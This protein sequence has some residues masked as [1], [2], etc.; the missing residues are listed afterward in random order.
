MLANPDRVAKPLRTCCTMEW[1]RGLGRSPKPG[2]SGPQHSSPRAVPSGGPTPR[3]PRA[4]PPPSGPRAPRGYLAIVPA[5]WQVAGRGAADAQRGRSVVALA[6]RADGRARGLAHVAGRVLAAAGPRQADRIKPASTAR[7]ARRAAAAHAV[8]VE[9]DGLILVG[10][11]HRGEHAAVLLARGLRRAARP[12]QVHGQVILR[13]PRAP[14]VRHTGPRP[15]ARPRPRPPA[16]SPGHR[17]APR[18][19]LGAGPRLP[20]RDCGPC[21]G[22]PGCG[23]GRGWGGAGAGPPGGCRR[24][25]RPATKDREAGTA[26]RAWRD[27]DVPSPQRRGRAAQPQC[28]RRTPSPRPQAERRAR[29]VRTTGTHTRPSTRRLVLA[30]Q[31]ITPYKH[32]RDVQTCRSTRESLTHTL[33][34][35]TQPLSRTSLVILH[36]HTCLYIFLVDHTHIHRH[37]PEIL[38]HP[39]QRTDSITPRLTAHPKRRSDIGYCIHSLSAVILSAPLVPGTFRALADSTVNRIDGVLPSGS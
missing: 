1:G 27:R 24:A 34:R 9:V 22:G 39:A 35:H 37:K 3:D 6:R 33:P 7:R 18:S 23:P 21:R 38:S 19:A 28:P 11:L 30:Q 17:R 2:G 29:G 25:P 14:P 32:V 31:T 8:R 20:R 5:E 10:A 13:V 36:T 26:A 15:A 12:R 4:P 16:R